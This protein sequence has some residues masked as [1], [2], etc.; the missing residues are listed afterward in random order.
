[1]WDKCAPYYE[2]ITGHV[3]MTEDIAFSTVLFYFAQSVATVPNDAYFYRANENASTNADRLPF[4]KFQKNM[5]DI[6]TVFDFVE[7]FLKDVNADLWICKD[8]K[9]FRKYYARMWRHLP[10]E[11]Y[12]GSEKVQGLKIMRQFCPEEDRGKL[13]EDIYVSFDIFD[14]LFVLAMDMGKL[15]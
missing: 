12:V 11:I 2:K 5:K 6:Q 9:E 4:V 14:V 10:N 7:D 1:M 15:L 8:F 3:I 13:S